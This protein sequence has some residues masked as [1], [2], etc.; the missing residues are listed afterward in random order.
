MEENI[1]KRFNFKDFPS[2]DELEKKTVLM[3]IN[4]DNAIDHP[5]PLEPNVIQVGGLQITEP[6][7][8]PQ[9]MHFNVFNRI[10]INNLCYRIY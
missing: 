4:S 8:L 9:V 6:K 1:R 7:E 10:L 3:L 5:E 2:L